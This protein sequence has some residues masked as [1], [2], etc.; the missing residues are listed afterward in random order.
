M[1]K[2]FRQPFSRVNVP[3]IMFGKWKKSVEIFKLQKQ[4]IMFATIDKCFP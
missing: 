4:E 2:G 3:S 1:D